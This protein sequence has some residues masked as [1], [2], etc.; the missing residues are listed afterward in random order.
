MDFRS[1]MPE[2]KEDIEVVSIDRGNAY[3]KALR[4]YLPHV[5][6]SFDPFHITKNVNDAVDEVRRDLCKSLEE[7]EKKLIKGKRYLFLCGEE[8]LTDDKR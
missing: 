5:S 2:Q 3:L 8:D 1:L 4:E 6:I 7:E